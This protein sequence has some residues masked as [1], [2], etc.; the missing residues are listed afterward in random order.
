MCKKCGKP[1]AGSANNHKPY[2]VCTRRED[3]DGTSCTRR[4]NALTLEAFVT[5]ATIELL[6]G[7]DLGG[8]PSATLALSE[9]DEAAIRADEA[10][11]KDMWDHHEPSTREY[12]AMRK[13]VL[14]PC[15]ARPSCALPSK[16]SQVWSDRAR[17]QPGNSWPNAGMASD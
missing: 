2:Y 14:R 7:L 15:G 6:T 4:I 17:G 3:R 5:D 12:R 8:A 1:M 11:L 10:E 16:S 13:T 9:V